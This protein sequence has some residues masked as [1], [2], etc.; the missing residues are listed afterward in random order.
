MTKAY[1]A[2][3]LGAESGRAMLGVLEDGKL[4]LHEMHRFAN[5]IHHLPDGYHWNTVGLWA[6]LKEGLAKSV[7]YCKDHGIELTS[8]GVDTWGVDFG[9]LGQSGSLL[10]VPFAYRDPRNEV[11][12][13]EVV[14]KIGSERLYGMTGIQFMPFNTLFQL[15]AW[16]KAEPNVLA[17]ART[18]LFTPDLLHYFFTGEAKIESSIASTSQ[19]IDPRTGQ[20]SNELL[21]KLGFPTDLLAKTVPPGTVIGTLRKEVAAETNAPVDL[22]VIAP[23]SHDTA[24]AVAA[25]PADASTN[26]MFLS[27]GTWSLMGLELVEPVLT[28]A[29]RAQNFTNEGGVDGTIR[30]LK[31]ISGLWLV[32]EVRR[33]Y[34]KDGV[35]YDYDALTRMA[36]EAE[37]FRTLVDPDHGPFMQPGDMPGKIA[38]FAEKTGQPKPESPGQFVRCCL[39]SLALTYRRTLEGMVEV[40]G[41]G[42]DVI[43]IVGGG[44]KNE[45]LDQMT[46][47][48]TSRTVVVGPY[49]ATAAGN[50]LVQAM[51]AGDLKDLNEIREVVKASFKPKTFSPGDSTDWDAAFERYTAVLG[52]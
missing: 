38:A 41:K 24:S 28:E 16:K 31:N 34:E 3:D 19:M 37:P 45:L 7:A 14:D 21:E 18:L 52:R 1:V 12:M 26:W 46:A 43:H 6:N 10:G 11:A 42:I 35:T 8:V 15:A 39:E 49:E 23:A 36:G 29:A 22:K 47:D 48:A 13:E 32:Q 44:G 17:A 4:S 20:W 30:F 2:F 5:V 33:A 27:S 9:L 40:T 50:L 51:G 25:V